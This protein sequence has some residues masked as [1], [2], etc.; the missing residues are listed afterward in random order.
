MFYLQLKESAIIESIV[1]YIRPLLQK[2]LQTKASTNAN[3]LMGIAV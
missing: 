3:I 2:L 1:R